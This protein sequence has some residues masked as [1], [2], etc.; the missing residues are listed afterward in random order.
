MKKK[1]FN[2]QT[3]KISNLERSEGALKEHFFFF[4]FTI[5]CKSDV[6]YEAFTITLLHYKRSKFVPAN[7]SDKSSNPVPGS[8]IQ[9]YENY[10][11]FNFPI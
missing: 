11:I 1:S 6:I 7:S 3:R 10:S 5:F 2:S 4:F 8:T 9:L